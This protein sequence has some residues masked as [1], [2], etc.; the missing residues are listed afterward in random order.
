ML[1]RSDVLYPPSIAPPTMALL[2][3]AGVDATYLEIDSDYGHFAPTAN[4]RDWGGAL[5]EFLATHA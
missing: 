1:S 2:S 5:G 3:D 4:G